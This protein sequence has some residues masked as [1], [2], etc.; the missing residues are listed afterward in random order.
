MAFA[1]VVAANPFERLWMG[2][3]LLRT[4]KPPAAAS[5]LRGKHETNGNA[6]TCTKKDIIISLQFQLGFRG[7]SGLT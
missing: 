7:G 3:L 5:L 2:G 1:T 6:G 4:C